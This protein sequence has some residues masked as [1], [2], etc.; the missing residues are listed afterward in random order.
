MLLLKI[1]QIEVKTEALRI[2]I[3]TINLKEIRI[4][5]LEIFL[6]AY[7][8]D[9]FGPNNPI[10]REQMAA[11]LYRY[12]QYKGYDVSDTADLSKFSDAAKISAYAKTPLAW[13]NAE[14]LIE[15]NGNGTINARGDAE[16]CQA[17]AILM[18]FCENVVK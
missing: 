18:R 12:A 11:I 8:S 14:A 13:A 9:Q 6:G 5:T 10:T 15:G 3:I 17:A 1:L 16:R 4:F 7:G 2:V